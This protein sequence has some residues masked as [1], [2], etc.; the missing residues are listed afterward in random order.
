ME[1]NGYPAQN[2]IY[3][4][5][6]TNGASLM[7]GNRQRRTRVL[8]VDEA[9]PYSPFSS[10]VPFN[11]D[12]I[13]VPSIGLRSSTSIFPN[14]EERRNARQGLENLNR[15][16]QA[17][18][19]SE[20]LQKS[21]NDLKEL[22]KPEG[23]AQFTFKTVPNITSSH[24]SN[25]LPNVTLS[26]FAKMVY[27]QTDQDPVP[28]AKD[29]SEIEAVLEV[30]AP[31]Q[32]AIL[33][34][35]KPQQTP[36]QQ[37][38]H[39]P[40]QSP[41][42]PTPSQGLAVVIPDLPSTFRPEDVDVPRP[43][44]VL[45]VQAPVQRAILPPF[46]PQQTPHQQRLHGPPQSPAAPT[47]SQGLA[48]VIPDLPSTFRPEEYEVAP[49]T[50][51]TPQHLSRKR[52]RSSAENDDGLSR[53]VDQREKAELALQNL[54]EYLGEIFEAEDQMQPGDVQ[55][56]QFFTAASE[57]ISL[58]I[59]AQ[60]KVETLLQKVITVGRF[61]QVPLDDLL[62]LQKL[63][64]CA[65]KD[66]EN[67]EVKVSE[68]MGES[69]VEAWLPQ[70]AI[71]EL[72]IKAAR[73]SLRLMSG[74]R[75]DKQLYSEDVIQSALNAFKNATETCIVPIVEMRSTGSTASLFKLLSSEK[76]TITNLLAQCR[77]LFALMATLVANI[78]LSETVINTLEFTTS[79]LIFVENAHSE[80]DSVLGVAR[81]DSLR[82]VAMD[83]L[84]QIFLC[85]PAQRQG[86]FDEILTSLEK[87]PV[88]KQ[89]ARQFKLPEGGSIQLVS[90]LI[91]RLIQT[92]A[93]KSDDTKDKRRRKALE[94]LNGEE[95]NG[96][97][98]DPAV[99][100]TTINSET[101]GEEQPVTAIQEL[102]EAVSPLLD[103]AR[104]NATYVVGFIV[105][106]AMKSTKSGDAPYRNLL[107]LF[108]ED[109]ITCL[110]S[111]D[112]PAAELLLRL[113]LYKMVQLA[114]G[115]KT[116]AP[117]KNM[118][119][120]LLGMMGAAISELTSHIR[121]TAGSLENGDSQLA[122]YLSRVA[123]ASLEKRASDAEIVSW[124]CGPY[125][126]C[127]EFLE[128]RASADGDPQ[129]TSAIG[130]FTAEWAS[131]ICTTFDSISGEDCDHVK[132]EKEYGRLAYRLRMMINDRRWLATEYSFDSVSP[133]HAR[134]AYSLTL[135][136][137][138]FCASF[139]RVLTILLGSMTS[140]QATVRSKSLKS[141][142]QV[143]DTD[144]TIIDTE[145]N[146]KLLIMRC[147]NDSSVQ[148]RDSALG[149]IGKCIAVR[150]ALEE[151]MIP[152]ILQRVNDT[153]VGV[154]KRAMKLSK[155]IYLRNSN[156]EVRSQIADSLLHRVTDLDEGVQELARQ[157]I[158]EV[159]MSPFYQSTSSG[160]Q[161]TQ[162]KL[163]M[164]DHVAL[165]VKTVQRSSGVA[166]VLDKVLQN[167]LS[168][169]AKHTAAN[170]KVCKAL[171]ATMFETI[172]DNTAGEG[173]DAPSAR[174]ALQIL[175]IFAKSNPQLFT[176]EQIQL[177]EPYIKNVGAGDDLAIYRSVVVIFRHVLPVL[178]KVHNTF[179]IEV[180]K[181]LIPAVSRLGKT[182]LDDVIACVWIIS[183]TL[184]D[185]QHL[186]RLVLSSLSQIQKMKGANLD[187]ITVKKLTK[188]LLITG[189]CGKHCNLDPQIDA[190]KQHFPNS[191]SKKDSK[192][193]SV[194]KLM[195]DTFAP[196]T[197]PSQPLEVRRAAL[198]AIGMVC[199]SWPKNFASANIYTTFLHVFEEEDSSLETI[200]MRA[201]KD[202]LTLEEKR[203]EVG[204]DGAP[205]AA[206]ES[207]A[208]LGVMGG[209]QGDGVALGIAQRFLNHII[210]VA[211][212]RQDEEGLLATEV[213]ASI[214]RQ[215][216]VHPKETGS[217]LIALETSTTSKIA[218]LAFKEHKALHEKHETILEKEYM[219][220]VH[221]AYEYQRDVVHDTHGA[222]LNPFASKL[223]MMMEV[224]KISKVKN[225]KRFYD[226][227]C[228]R[229]EF[230][231]A[232]IDIGE[233][234]HH[235]D[236]S[237]FIIENM[238]FF[239]YATM[240]ELLSA[241][242]AM[243]KVVA[244]M[245]TSIAHAIETELFHVSLK[246][247]SQIDENG[248]SQ[249][250][251]PTIDPLRLKLLTASSM[252][253]SCL[254]ET[255]TYLRRQYGIKSNRQEGKNKGAAKDLN[256]APVK[257][258]GVNGDKYWDQIG[259][260]MRS[261]ETEVSMMNQCRA[262][263]E[264]LSVDQEF[265]IAADGEE[266]AEQTRLSTPS[267]N[268]ENGAASTPAPPGS[269]RGRKRK[270]SDTPGGRK[271]RA[272]S[273]STGPRPRGRPKGLGKK[274]GVEKSDDEGGDW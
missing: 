123:E 261:M 122:K 219:R 39:G 191:F 34:P 22:L 208:K 40:P 160:N 244:A 79:R 121:K 214:A 139:G 192:D 108:I 105:G 176:A 198:D 263:V 109:F 235:L 220:A 99:G 268:E 188:I 70:L 238:A 113:F 186:T 23:I 150:P 78:E 61:S 57:G 200:I 56:S 239:E 148:V 249:P 161:S 46:K 88:T 87:L 242:N 229:I 53:S 225:R 187:E 146:V 145:R 65:L 37:R 6:G 162:F 253:L 89:S 231:P 181:A 213:V 206:A 67:V 196:F 273:S 82:V 110:N 228:A 72:G 115:E 35:F 149:L 266:D 127:L 179:L 222:T 193:A 111:P 106:R 147:A 227:L 97:P 49:E 270:G 116:P 63:S 167:M 93:S 256:R 202:F 205:S 223:A 144:P 10:V 107:D 184:G 267:D 51:D 91:M 132:V 247:P 3:G 25:K 133:P 85:N 185:F 172:I 29:T 17:P 226:N 173:D 254:W 243:E 252:L 71:A 131:K 30:Q 258:Q 50:P 14:E 245:G 31:V 103:T 140:D 12:I 90:A 142:N 224:M 215:G 92:S 164:A 44:A 9:L 117:A 128:D 216:L 73:T 102:R 43:K 47:P 201:F 195:A 217:S 15:D 170:F 64:E 183:E 114:E 134:L 27:D 207:A 24:T 174:D 246:Q 199:Q 26:P 250:I 237:Q 4:S 96:S 274:Q 204:K 32:R 168:T 77:R 52:R 54:R 69:E 259:P 143:L 98:S 83:V 19:T 210:Q 80:R 232:K 212:S 269:G 236:F 18:N 233:V 135:L 180:R 166:T 221:L 120:D 251:Q 265:K 76:K 129:L 11:S 157:T 2:G 66:A 16:A 84:A 163:A 86:I 257:A 42:A 138:A 104:G 1:A 112:W 218:D 101:R 8:T 203:S 33:P 58:S 75:E 158:E 94:A 137:S 262:F 159:W 189:M 136:H 28:E 264:L 119:L 55:S 100:R 48:V 59:N 182:I 171:V 68:D 118:A 211:L 234:G 141:V 154:R 156:R 169:E 95:A 124:P 155:D 271:K 230:D 20:R 125:R 177:L 36:H 41:A 45:E 126:A 130:S 165:M 21:L 248:Q 190:F 178:P 255:R 74:G 7:N 272:R 241:I 194:S 151:E 5:N 209:G 197:L 240:D 260:I 152:S 38:L 81:F 60:T 62:R 13:P 175:T 153:G